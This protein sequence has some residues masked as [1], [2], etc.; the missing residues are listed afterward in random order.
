MD[1]GGMAVNEVR[2]GRVSSRAHAYRKELRVILPDPLDDDLYLP[3]R[4][5][6]PCVLLVDQHPAVFFCLREVTS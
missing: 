1:R 2:K 4:S 6:G 3:L 5:P